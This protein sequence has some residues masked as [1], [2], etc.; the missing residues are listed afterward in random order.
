[1][2]DDLARFLF[3][4]PT[5]FHTVESVGDI[6]QRCGFSQLEEGDSWAA[7]RASRPVQ[8]FFCRRGGS[9]IA[10]I[11]SSKRPRGFRL[12]GAHTDSPCFKLKLESAHFSCGVLAAHV[13]VYGSPIFATYTDRGLA[14]AGIALPASP[15]GPAEAGEPR[16]IHSGQAVAMLPNLAIHLN[17]EV[18][19]KL[20]YNPQTQLKAV[21]GSVSP[22]NDKTSDETAAAWLR[23]KLGLREGEVCDLQLCSSQ[24][25]ARLGREGDLFSGARLDDTAMVH[26]ILNELC[27][28]S[29]G[30]PSHSWPVAI[31]CNGEEVG[32]RTY[33]GA[34]SNFT[35]TVLRRIVGVSGEGEPLEELFPRA[36]AHSFFLSLDGAHASH[37]SYPDA[38]DANYEVKMGGGP[39]LK[40]PNGASYS[41]EAFSIAWIRKVAA[42]AGCNLQSAVPRSDMAT[43]STIGPILSSCLGV[44]GVDIGLP[45]YAMHSIQ[46]TISLRDYGALQNLTRE[47]FR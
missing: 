16:Y 11:H 4:N 23:R 30:G 40:L 47:Y 21:F 24:K 18:N 13:S 10:W 7:L 17:R 26:L 34:A 42:L 19:S 41:S 37:P 38:F 31:F 27:Q 22:G 20:S 1:M 2:S 32:S 12:A 6:L 8:G 5:P 43:G 35:S 3:E 33:E 39:A 9:L 36:M 28:R 15:T 25:P 46:E 29:E 44:R 45:M 14:V